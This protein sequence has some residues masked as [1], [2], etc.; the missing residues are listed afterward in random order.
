MNRNP[1]PRWGIRLV[2]QIRNL[3]QAKMI[4]QSKEICCDEKKKR[5]LTSIKI[6]TT[7][8]NKSEGNSKRRQAKKYRDRIKQTKQDIPK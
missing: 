5:N 8:G 4:R 2:T 3:Q 7:R 6:N 1:K